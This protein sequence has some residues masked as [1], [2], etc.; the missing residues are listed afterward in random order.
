MRLYRL[1]LLTFI[2]A[3][4]EAV[5]DA[6][7][8]FSDRRVI[9]GGIL[10]HL[11]P[12]AYT[13]PRIEQMEYDASLLT[14]KGYPL[15]II[16]NRVPKSASTTL[17]NLF[18]DQASQRKFTIYNKEIYVP[19]LLSTDV[20]REV[21]YELDSAKTPVFYERHMY[22]IFGDDFQKPQPVYINVIRD[23]LEQVISAYYYSRETCNTEKRC[24]FNTTFL[25]ETLDDCVSKRPAERCIDASQGVISSLPFFCGNLVECEENKTFALERAKQN[26]IDYY[27]VV[28]IVEELYNFLF[29]LENLMPRYFANIRLQYM[30]NGRTRIENVGVHRGN[31][32]E[33]SETSRGILTLALANEYELYEFIKQRFYAQFQQVLK[34]YTNQN[35]GYS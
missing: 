14:I 7:D 30:A 11:Q 15:Y 28:G 4:M 1:I 21:M 34:K 25:N 29:V 22:F 27:T 2:V 5:S 19:F 9:H 26:I 18:R 6:S 31:Y 35:L 12:S 33:L 24:Y 23:P 32:T 16:Y 10:C 13:C 8:T 17:R 3:R 20:Q